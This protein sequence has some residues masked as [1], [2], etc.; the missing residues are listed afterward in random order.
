M[1]TS[2]LP[3]GARGTTAVTVSRPSMQWYLTLAG[4]VLLIVGSLLSWCYDEGC[5]AM[6]A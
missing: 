6:S 5:S 4:V 1:N 3:N 2:T